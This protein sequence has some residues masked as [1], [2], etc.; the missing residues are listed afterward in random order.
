MD[1]YV[2]APVEFSDDEVDAKHCTLMGLPRMQTVF[3]NLQGHDRSHIRKKAPPPPTSS[4]V[5]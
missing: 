2:E 4:R 3:G 5:V 1:T